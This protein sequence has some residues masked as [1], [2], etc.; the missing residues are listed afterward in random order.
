MHALSMRV[1][2][3]SLA[4]TIVLL[5]GLGALGACADETTAPPLTT[6]ARV[7]ANAAAPGQEPYTT[8]VD[9]VVER[10]ADS[11][12]YGTTVRIRPICSTTQVFDLIVDLEQ[13]LKADQGRQLVKGSATVP[14]YTCDEA[15]PS[16][17]LVVSQSTRLDF[18]PGR[19]MLRVRNANYQ[20]GVEPVDFTSRVRIVAD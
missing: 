18:Q 5:L 19:G 7:A 4:R 9:I 2:R 8:S 12:V 17:I 20:P 15:G 10:V 14:G 11:P 6:P 1:G 3:R 13:Q 16:L